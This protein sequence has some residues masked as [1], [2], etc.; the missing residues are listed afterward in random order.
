ML[1]LISVQILE[2]M[3]L[4]YLFLCQFNLS[5]VLLVLLEL[6]ESAVGLRELVTAV[7]YEVEDVEA[8]AGSLLSTIRR[9]AFALW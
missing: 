6:L 7:F 3:L 1:A 4:L 2:N 5:L 8:T 9:L